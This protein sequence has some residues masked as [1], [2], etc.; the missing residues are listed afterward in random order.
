MLRASLRD[1][2]ERLVVIRPIGDNQ[3]AGG[4]YIRFIDGSSLIGASSM[5]Q[6]GLKIELETGFEDVEITLPRAAAGVAEHLGEGDL[7]MVMKI[8][9]HACRYPAQDASLNGPIVHIQVGKTSQ[10]F[11]MHRSLLLPKKNF[12]RVSNGRICLCAYRADGSRR[13]ESNCCKRKSRQRYLSG[14]QTRSY[15]G[16]RPGMTRVHSPKPPRFRSSSRPQPQCILCRPERVRDG[17]QDAFAG[18]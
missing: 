1:R 16:I 2:L 6:C 5:G 10:Q 18:R 14:R 8:P 11:P 9:V 12:I 3:H 17:F 13:S 7:G 15:S 4:K